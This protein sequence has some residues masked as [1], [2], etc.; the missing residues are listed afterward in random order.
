MDLNPITKWKTSNT[1]RSKLEQSPHS[2]AHAVI[3]DAC[4]VIVCCASWCAAIA[5]RVHAA[6]ST[7][8]SA[9]ARGS[10][11]VAGT[12]SASARSRQVGPSRRSARGATTS[13]VL[14]EADN[15]EPRRTAWLR[16]L[17]VDRRAQLAVAADAIPKC[18]SARLSCKA[19]ASTPRPVTAPSSVCHGAPRMPAARRHEESVSWRSTVLYVSEAERGSPGPPERPLS[20]VSRRWH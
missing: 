4:S 7:H 20:I 9:K 12:W 19:G 6:H 18:S 10:T 8:K 16:H 11:V 5:V 3:S 2:L 14:V 13:R 15:L 1:S 17:D